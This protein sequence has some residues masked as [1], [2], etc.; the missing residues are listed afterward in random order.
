VNYYV[1]PSSIVDDGAEIGEGTKIW[2]FSHICSGAKIGK[3]CSF[4]QNV[5]VAPGVVIGDYVRVQNGVSLYTGLVIEDY[6]FI[7]PHAV[8]TNDRNPRSCGPWKLEQTF[9]RRG[10]SVG[11]NA[12][13]VCGI[14]MGEFSMAGCGSVVTRT[15]APRTLVM[16]NPARP[17]RVFTL[18]ELKEKF[19]ML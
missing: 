10:A 2:H 17:R 4:G 5:Y 18:E 14:E 16:G 9:L 6:C 12:S 8:F 19:S 3:H 15:V 1:H 11:A 13:V 7:G